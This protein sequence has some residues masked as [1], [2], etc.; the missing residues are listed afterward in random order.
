MEKEKFLKTCSELY[1]NGQSFV[2]FALND[3]ATEMFEQGLGPIP[4]LNRLY[5]IKQDVKYSEP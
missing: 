4:L 2:F 3:P 1:D 5:I